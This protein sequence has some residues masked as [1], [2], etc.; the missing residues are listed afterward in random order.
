MYRLPQPCSAGTDHPQ[1][2]EGGDTQL[3]IVK[4]NSR[5]K[6]VHESTLAE[7]T[8]TITKMHIQADTK[9]TGPP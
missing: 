3:S 6:D 7:Q 5:K 8:V 1:A 9:A 4:K 2:G